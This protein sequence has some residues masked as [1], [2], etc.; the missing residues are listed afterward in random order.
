M[1]PEY[2]GSD[3]WALGL[4]RAY[5]VEKGFLFRA[6]TKGPCKYP[7]MCGGAIYIL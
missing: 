5:R 7:K 6:Y 4:F 3:V 2:G 1:G